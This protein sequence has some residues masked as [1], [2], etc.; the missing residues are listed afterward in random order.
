MRLFLAAAV[1]SAAS[2]ASA[3][4][5]VMRVQVATCPGR[6][7][8]PYSYPAVGSCP[9]E[10]GG[11]FHPGRY[12]SCDDRYEKSFWRRW[13]R[14]HFCGGSM[15]DGVP[16]RCVSPPGRSVSIRPEPLPAEPQAVDQSPAVPIP[17]EN[18]AS[19]GTEAVEIH[20]D[21]KAP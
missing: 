11:C 6:G 2:A 7:Y 16:C 10:D 3:A 13:A 8:V 21:S 15:L 20:N 17:P 9:C 14:A 4:E 19:A 12:Y 1:I 5:P 18:A